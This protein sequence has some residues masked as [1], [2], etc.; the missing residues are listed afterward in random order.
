MA[1]TQRRQMS[2]AFATAIFIILSGGLQDA[3]TYCCRGGLEYQSAAASLWRTGQALVIIAL[4]A[5]G[6]VVRFLFFIIAASPLADALQNR[7]NRA[8]F[9][10]QG[11]FHPG[12]DLVIGPA[13]DHI[14]CQE[15][16][17]ICLRSAL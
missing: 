12:R 1:N 14:V 13:L 15:I 4:L 9:F 6:H 3:Y 5:L 16:L 10:R 11:V 8:S 2:D 17:P 7:D